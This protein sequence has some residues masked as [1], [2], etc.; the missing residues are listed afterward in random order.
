[1]RLIHR[2]VLEPELERGR[3]VLDPEIAMLG[4]HELR[5][6][7]E[8]MRVAT[9]RGKLCAVGVGG[10]EEVAVHFLAP[11]AFGHVAGG[12]IRAHPNVAR[13]LVAAAV[14]P[15][16]RVERVVDGDV[17][18]DPSMKPF[19]QLQAAAQKQVVG[20]LVVRRAIIEIDHR[21]V[22]RQGEHRHRLGVGRPVQA[23]L[24][25]ALQD[26]ARQRHFMVELR[27]DGLSQGHR[28]F[29]FFVLVIVIVIVTENTISDAKDREGPRRVAKKKYQ[30]S[31][32]RS[33]LR[34]TI[35]IH[36][37]NSS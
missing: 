4:V 1:M 37:G 21:Q 10:G 23:V 27:E 20:D 33:S 8:R 2:K 32:D 35:F 11:L 19:A 6:A 18:P 15:Y 22:G 9:V 24:G 34:W 3:A 29:S 28:F 13:H 5:I 17:I 31:D 7:H 26:L 25:D 12:A 14:I 36:A 16:M 30:I